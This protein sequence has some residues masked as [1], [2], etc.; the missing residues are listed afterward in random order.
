MVQFFPS[1]GLPNGAPKSEQLVY[2]ALKKLPAHWVV[3]HSLGLHVWGSRFAHDGEADFVLLSPKAGLLLLEAK[4]GRYEVTKG[5]WFTFPAGKRT[6][7]RKSPFQQASEN[8]RRVLQY[9]LDNSTVKSL[10]SGHGVI[11]TDGVP[12]E[13]LGPEAH[14]NIVLG[15][16]DLADPAQAIQQL[17]NHWTAQGWNESDFSQVVDTLLPTFTVKSGIDVNLSYA[18]Q[19]QD[20]RTAQTIE[21][22]LDQLDVVQSFGSEPRVA[23]YGSAGT[24]KTLLLRERATQL[25]RGGKR[26]ALI[27]DRSNLDRLSIPAEIRSDLVICGSVHEVLSQLGSTSTDIEE[28]ILEALE[29]VATPPLDALLIDEA[30]TMTADAVASLM[31]LLANPK[32]DQVL[33]AADPRQ[34]D[35]EWNAPEGFELHALTVN[36]RNTGEVSR[37]CVSLVKAP[38]SQTQRSSIK[39]RLFRTNGLEGQLEVAVERVTEHVRRFG[40]EHVYAVAVGLD[41][42]LLIKR[43]RRSGITVTEV[44]TGA[45]L[46][47]ASP[48]A[49]RGGEAKAVV[50]VTG[51]GQ[52]TRVSDYIAISRSRLIVDVVAVDDT[53]SPH[54]K[55]LE[56]MANASDPD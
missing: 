50:Y 10:P 33:I 40:T 54:G 11:F 13:R 56:R 25:A 9:I 6:K 48:D 22:T 23:I 41:R 35:T 20:I 38:Y 18:E 44:P 32:S 52:R 7:M 31:T 1:S 46:F 29:C 55:H 39:P 36:C 17:C 42:A 8:K 19:Q 53:W 15:Q 45:G 47:V 49:V 12:P 14:P 34:S 37:L 28:A 2:E 16:L 3:I 43:I 27:C 5:Q 26:V 24:G 51:E 4:G 30:Q 21:W